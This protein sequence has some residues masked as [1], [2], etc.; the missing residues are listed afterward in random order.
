MSRGDAAARMGDWSQ[1]LAHYYD[2]IG[3]IT[4]RTAA[5]TIAAVHIAASSTQLRLGS[6]HSALR[7]AEMSLAACSTA[8]RAHGARGAA[9]EALG[10]VADA[11][12]AFAEAA[13]LEPERVEHAEHA[14]RLLPL[15]GLL[16]GLLGSVATCGEW[17]AADDALTTAQCALVDR[18]RHAVAEWALA[19]HLLP[20]PT[21]AR[22]LG[23]DA[24]ESSAPRRTQRRLLALLG[25]DAAVEAA[26]AASPGGQHNACDAMRT[27][28]LCKA[29]ELGLDVASELV[30]AAVGAADDDD[31]QSGDE[32]EGEGEG[33]EEGPVAS[34]EVHVE[35][36]LGRL[37]VQFELA[38]LRQRLTLSL[39]SLN[40]ADLGEAR[41]RFTFAVGLTSAYLLEAES[42]EL[43]YVEFAE[44]RSAE[45]GALVLA[46]GLP[47]AA[48]V[49][50][51]AKAFVD[52][53]RCGEG[54]R[55]PIAPRDAYANA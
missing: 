5:E 44:W 39:L 47:P 36:A 9:L 35:G 1:A 46:E 55:P 29:A 49:E 10:L 3:A 19:P 34:E 51:R 18:L 42:H 26:R 2:A 28:L 54:A 25:V 27:W 30:R 14:A 21:P 38:P 20:L 32:G 8:A 11:H 13:R 40:A 4:K 52:F 53:F 48:S 37:L 41:L 22:V 31:A 15:R 45:R 23:D 33:D 7:H 17:A 16:R 50:R 43:P 6:M 24:F 12:A